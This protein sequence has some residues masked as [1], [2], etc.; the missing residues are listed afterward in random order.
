MKHFNALCEWYFCCCLKSSPKNTQTFLSL[1]ETIDNKE[2][3]PQSFLNALDEFPLFEIWMQIY[4]LPKM[5]YSFHRNDIANELKQTRIDKFFDYLINSL[6]MELKQGFENV[7]DCYFRED[8]KGILDGISLIISQLKRPDIVQAGL[9]TKNFEVPYLDMLE[10]LPHNILMSFI[11][12]L[13]DNVES[14]I[15]FRNYFESKPIIRNFIEEGTLHKFGR[16]SFLLSIFIENSVTDGGY[17]DEILHKLWKCSTV[18]EMEPDIVYA[19]ISTKYGKNNIKSFEMKDQLLEDLFFEYKSLENL[20]KLITQFDANNYLEKIFRAKMMGLDSENPEEITALPIII[21]QSALLNYAIKLDPDRLAKYLTENKYWELSGN[22]REMEVEIFSRVESFRTH[23]REKEKVV[24]NSEYIIKQFSSL[25]RLKISDVRKILIKIKPNREQN[26]T[27]YTFDINPKYNWI[28]YSPWINLN[29]HPGGNYWFTKLGDKIRYPMVLKSVNLIRLIDSALIAQK[30][31]QNVQNDINTDEFVSLIVHASDVISIFRPWLK[32]CENEAIITD[33]KIKKINVDLTGFALFQHRQIQIIQRGYYQS[34]KPERFYELLKRLNESTHTVNIQSEKYLFSNVIFPQTLLS[35]I[36]DC[37]MGAYANNPA[38]KWIKYLE[39]IYNIFKMNAEKQDDRN[40]RNS[41]LLIRYLLKRELNDLSIEEDWEKS[42]TGWEMPFEKLLLS[43]KLPP[44]NWLK[45]D[46]KETPNIKPINIS[47]RIAQRYIASISQKRFILNHPTEEWKNNWI[48]FLCNLNFKIDLNRFLSIL[49]TELV[50]DKILFNKLDIEEKELLFYVLLEFGNAYNLDRLFNVFFSKI[51]SSYFIEGDKHTLDLRLELLQGMY[52]AVWIYSKFGQRRLKAEDPLRNKLEEL[53]KLE[54]LKDYI[55][56]IIMYERKYMSIQNPLLGKLRELEEKN[57]SGKYLLQSSRIINGSVQTTSEESYILLPIIDDANFGMNLSAAVYDPQ[58]KTMKIIIDDFDLSG[59]A[60]LFM[61]GLDEKSIN[62]ALHKNHNDALAFYIGS[63]K[64]REGV[65]CH[66][67]NCGLKD[68]VCQVNSIE[69]LTYNYAD[70]VKIRLCWD[71]Q[72]KKRT[73]QDNVI[74]LVRKKDS[75]PNLIHKAEVRYGKNEFSVIEL[76]GAGKESIL[77]LETNII[78]KWYPDIS[79]IYANFEFIEKVDFVVNREG[80]KEPIYKKLTELL[81]SS[82]DNFPIIIL[83]FIETKICPETGK[84]AL[85]FSL[86]PGK[87]YLLYYDEFCEEDIVLLLDEIKRLSNP[88]GLIVNFKPVFIEE[89][90][91]LSL[92][93][94]NSIYSIENYDNLKSPFD[95]RNL[96][97]K[98]IFNMDAFSELIGK[99][100]KNT[101]SEDEDLYEISDPGSL[102]AK[103]IKNTNDWFYHLERNRI[104]GFPEKIKIVW[105][106]N[107]YPN[108]D[109]VEFIKSAWNDVGQRKCSVKCSYVDVFKIESYNYVKHLNKY[110]MMNQYDIIQIT[111]AFLSKGTGPGKTGIRGITNELINVWVDSDSMTLRP[112]SGEISKINQEYY[113]GRDFY[114]S[115]NPE[116]KTLQNAISIQCPEQVYNMWNDGFF[117]GIFVCKPK[118]PRI[119]SRYTVVW[120]KGNG[121]SYEF[122]APTEIIIHTPLKTPIQLYFKI[123]AEAI[124][125]DWKCK[126]SSRRINVRGLWNISENESRPTG[127]YVGRLNNFSA[128]ETKGGCLEKSEVSSK[129]LQNN[130]W[131]VSQLG[132][133]L[134]WRISV[135]SDVRFMEGFTQ[136]K[137]PR[138]VILKDVNLEEENLTLSG[139]YTSDIRRF[140][141]LKHDFIIVEKK[142]GLDTPA[143]DPTRKYKK[144]LDDYF[145]NL[146]PISL[147]ARYFAESDCIEI[148]DQNYRF[149]VIQHGSVKWIRQ[150]NVHRDGGPFITTAVYSPVAKACLIKEGQQY[151]ASFKINYENLD[152]FRGARGLN[153]VIYLNSYLYYVGEVTIDPVTSLELNETHHRFESG[154][155]QNFLF[156]ESKLLY[157]GQKFDVLDNVLYPGDSVSSVRFELQGSTIILNIQVIHYSEGRTLFYQKNKYDLL[158]ILHLKNVNGTVVVDYVEGFDN[159]KNEGYRKYFRSN[160]ILND[161]DKTKILARFNNNPEKERSVIL[162]RLNEDKFIKNKKVEYDHVVLS[163]FETVERNRLLS[164]EKFLFN[165]VAIQKISNDYILVLEP[166]RDFDIEDIGNDIMNASIIV[167]KRQFSVREDMLG[168]LASVKDYCQKNKLILARLIY[169]SGKKRIEASM[170]EG[171]PPRNMEVLNNLIRDGKCYYGTFYKYLDEAKNILIIELSPGVFVHIDAL[172]HIINDKNKIVERDRLKIEE[173]ES[174]NGGKTVNKKYKIS[175]AFHGDASFI[176]EEKRPAVVLPLSNLFNR[177][178]FENK[179]FTLKYWSNNNFTIGDFPN[180]VAGI[181]FQEFVWN[182][183]GK[184]NL[185]GVIKLMSNNHPKIATISRIQEYNGYR[186]LISPAVNINSGLL[187]INKEDLSVRFHSYGVNNNSEKLRWENLSFFDLSVEEI[188]NRIH[189]EIWTYHDSETGTWIKKESGF[190]IQYQTLLPN[191][192]EYHFDSTEKSPGIIFF[193]KGNDGLYLRYKC[194]EFEKYGLPIRVLIQSLSNKHSGATYAFAGR[195]ANDTMW[196][197]IIP[198]RIAQLSEKLIVWN[199][200]GLEISM[201]NFNWQN[202]A[203]GDLLELELLVKNDL[204]IE[205]ISFIKWKEGVRN[206]LGEKKCFIPV[207]ENNSDIGELLLG[208]KNLSVKLPIVIPEIKAGSIVILN[209]ENKISLL[210]SQTGSKNY[211]SQD[212]TV[213]ISVVDKSFKVI[214]FEDF[215]V[216]PEI[217][218]HAADWKNDH[219]FT[220]FFKMNEDGIISSN[221]NGFQ[222]FLDLIDGPIPVTVEYINIEKKLIYFSRRFQNNPDFIRD[223]QKSIAKIVGYSK[224]TN[225]LILKSGSQFFLL[226]GNKLISGIPEEVFLIKTFVESFKLREIWI[227]KENGLIEC[228]IISDLSKDKSTNNSEKDIK[229][230]FSEIISEKSDSELIKGV[231]C[232]SHDSLMYYWIPE[233][234]LTWTKLSV[235]QFRNIFINNARTG[236]KAKLKTV[237]GITYASIIEVHEIKNEFRSLELGIEIQVFVIGKYE[238]QSSNETHYLV[239]STR[240]G[241]V[242]RCITIGTSDLGNVGRDMRVS[243]EIIDKVWGVPSSIISR[244]GIKTIKLDFPSSFESMDAVYKNL[245]SMTDAEVTAKLDEYSEIQFKDFTLDEIERYLYLFYRKGDSLNYEKMEKLSDEWYRR[246]FSRSHYYLAY[247]IIAILI[248]NKSQTRR[249]SA[250]K[251]LKQICIRAFRS[252]H[253]D[254][255][256]NSWFYNSDLSYTN[257]YWLTRLNKNR[258]ILTKANLLPEDKDNIITF[259][260]AIYLRQEKDLIQIAEAVNAALGEESDILLLKNKG[261]ITGRLI[262]LYKTIPINVE[263]FSITEKQLNVLKEILA[264]INNGRSMILQDRFLDNIKYDIDND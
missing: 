185:S 36:M 57:I 218:H 126:I 46:W 250:I 14:K 129:N 207:L 264:D 220:L 106:E 78:E 145:S 135:E 183:G 44:E 149:P 62:E 35:W 11:N 204:D 98:N 216:L 261:E 176:G 164:K 228:G 155:G 95:Y 123:T 247:A 257:N 93:K 146:R 239:Q 94:N 99:F 161:T 81:L 73:V 111:N 159:T 212:D 193:S 75:G 5:L 236:F 56:R 109:Q 167:L 255:L 201:E 50:E 205:K 171:M 233:K 132:T 175:I 91:K 254:V 152:E 182:N 15:E 178:V 138:A 13:A 243:V 16:L 222:E 136:N 27:K 225:K 61:T 223:G 21:W 104:Q 156:P 125:G 160:A 45:K 71:S 2:T 105:D 217:K 196:V 86:N 47:I 186:N 210:T 114:I 20:R 141:E 103:K 150:L 3:D 162:G 252:I 100:E 165:M 70:A 69:N 52:Q 168:K 85:L 238:V 174:E 68:Y 131:K 259:I 213:F 166:Y 140:F 97:W 107:H 10:Y 54:V 177:S 240:S 79:R 263:N 172:E 18:P 119:S 209:Y 110:L 64:I 4:S 133:K 38:G 246:S 43:P 29:R 226:S 230:E 9:N 7:I 12:D 76:L 262:N 192:I 253:V 179:I 55:N 221:L 25:L 112:I 1:L 101:E 88:T 33:N 32:A 190:E 188:I 121:D 80:K 6:P 206:L 142:G 147:D 157:K 127:E 59:I 23:G 84:Y 24:Q 187:E 113:N 251:L 170:I 8:F 120:Y 130:K 102:I 199:N 144:T 169:N 258:A 72:L 256:L 37:Y 53:L 200:K 89:K 154:Y 242:F 184:D 22:H 241:M 231:I 122:S 30:I 249:K 163:F 244:Y 232:K 90:V 66:N 124:E 158:H 195:S 17:Q 83:T 108:G 202:V 137:D 260:N 116:F 224:I 31:I 28:F 194:H 117:Q 235:S 173:A 42:K 198:G 118:D 248:L 34:L 245:A 208:S 189:N 237:R 92:I 51:E 181:N 115:R 60:N 74:E 63:E 151:F 77:K 215:S 203:V 26:K 180:L 48:Q 211:P 229:I 58:S 40:K 227:R 143:E 153:R 67:F 128:Y 219:L 234:C 39:D 65:Y 19:Y 214:G 134:N 82:D 49:L 191:T 87:N 96:K 148:F 139:K 41:A 197:E